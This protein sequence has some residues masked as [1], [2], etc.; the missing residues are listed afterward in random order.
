MLQLDVAKEFMEGNRTLADQVW[1]N[2]TEVFN[3]WNASVHQLEAGRDESDLNDYC[4]AE[5]EADADAGTA[6]TAAGVS[7]IPDWVPSNP[8]QH[9]HERRDNRR[10]LQ[11]VPGCTS[12]DR[13]QKITCELNTSSHRM[14]EATFSISK[15]VNL[16]GNVAVTVAQGNYIPYVIEVVVAMSAERAL[17]EEIML[18]LSLIEQRLNNL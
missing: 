5:A 10:K 4:L 1:V 6:A 8:N 18:T 3:V 12:P 15:L 7:S 9:Q 17:A 14:D 13:N 11:R 2:H 16:S